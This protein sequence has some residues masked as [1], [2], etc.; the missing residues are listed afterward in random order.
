MN[1]VYLKVADAK[2]SNLLTESDFATFANL[3]GMG[4]T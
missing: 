4:S 2:I 3:S 1:N